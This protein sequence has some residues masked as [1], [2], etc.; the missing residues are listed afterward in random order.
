MENNWN[1]YKIEIKKAMIER[2]I[3]NIKLSKAIGMSKTYVSSVITGYISSEP[4][5]NKICQYLG[6]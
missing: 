3:G 2:D 5:R 1:Q 4:A 6:R